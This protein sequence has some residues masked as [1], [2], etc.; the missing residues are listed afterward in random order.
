ML[1]APTLDHV[2][3]HPR[4]ED[5]AACCILL[6]PPFTKVGKDEIIPRLG[7]LDN[8]SAQYVHFYCAGYGGY[9]HPSFVPDMQ[10]IGKV[11][12]EGGTMIP[13]AFSQ[14]LFAEF[15]DQLEHATTWKYSG[16]SELIFL[17]PSVD[18]SNALVLHIDAMVR[19]GG[20]GNSAELFEGIIRYCKNATGEANAF[21]FSD[22]SG[23]KEM[24]KAA[25]ES[26]LSILPKSAQGLWK[27]GQH[28]AIRDIAA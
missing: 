21:D 25:I 16:N 3:A 12:Y 7:Y 14:K 2:M 6:A 26:L 15:I 11:K 1:E 17:G 19:D 8:R 23:A 24:G 20:I 4:R 18:F 13:W 5:G 22:I 27:K 28:Y 10:D 9:W